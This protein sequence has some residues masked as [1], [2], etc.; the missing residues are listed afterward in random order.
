M[1][2]G[3]IFTKGQITKEYPDQLVKQLASLPTNTTNIIHHI[4]SP[5]GNCYAAWAGYHELMKVNLP[6]ESIIEGE[7][8][9]MATFLAIAPA[10]KVTILYPSTFMIHEPFFPEGVGGS[11]DELESAKQELVQIRQSMAEAYAKKTGKPVQEMLALMN[12]TTRMDAHMAKSMGFVDVVSEP[13]RVA[14][15]MMDELKADFKTL[16]TD[17]MNLFKTKASALSIVPAKAAPATPPPA[18]APAPPKMSVDI[19]LT[20]AG[21]LSVDAP[22]EDSLIGAAALLNGAQA[23]DGDYTSMDGDVITV[24]GGVV[25]A[26]TP[27]VPNQQA[28][29]QLAQQLQALQTQLTAITAKQAEEVKAKADAEKVVAD[30]KKAEEL[31]NALKE[32]E[33]AVVALSKEVEDLK[34][35]TIGE[36]GKPDMKKTPQAFGLRAAPSAIGLELSQHFIAQEMPW[37][38]DH[39]KMRGL[40]TDFFRKYGNNAEGPV[41]TSIL[42]TQ[43]NFTYPGILTTDVLYKP[44]IDTPAIADMFTIDQNIK[45]Q[46]QYNLVQVLSNI[47]K[48]YNG[49]GPT[50]GN[51]NST[52]DNIVNATVQTKEFRMEE[53][54][55][56]DDFTQQLT[57]VYN[58]LAQEW[59]KTGESS[60]DPAGTPIDSI[61][62]EVLIDALRRDVFQRLTMA[63]SNSSSANFNQI[64][65][66]WDRLID[67]SGASNYCVLRAQGIAGLGVGTISAATATAALEAVYIQ[68]ATILKQQFNK[69][70]FWVT[71]SVYDAYI[72]QI[73]GTGNVSQA[74]YEN[75]IYGIEG[76]K[77]WDGGVPYKG[78]MVRPVR[79]WDTSLAD[80][81]NPLNAT[82]RHLVLLTIKQNHIAGVE[83]GADLNKIYSWYENKD[84]KRYYRADMKMGY[85]Y[86][87]CDLQTIAF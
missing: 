64:D 75:L 50:S 4:C 39:Y 10:N 24:V 1:I 68:S 81:N 49:C 71:G 72:N 2:E 56:K 70:T 36:P 61:I 62:Q 83:N 87:H 37:L 55:C 79:F 63:A 57:G 78:I 84:S 26:V 47:L 14:A 6:I 16:K 29:L 82:T 20:D 53:A 17:I 65:G 58:N 12:K 22:N 33:L 69:A 66:L 40:N 54:W 86:L 19:Q 67:S 80:T 48:P 18:P 41:M 59:L 46:K 28:Q 13:R 25:S 44:S 5:G 7:A 42:Q 85:N 73:V 74:Q 11:V 30:A 9:S 45:F 31:A 23:P 21:V 35:K 51:S 27:T 60:F 43:F 52:R 34:K 38:E 76:N 77:T 3:H 8:Q 15:E 32:K